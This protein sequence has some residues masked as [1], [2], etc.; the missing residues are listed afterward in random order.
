MLVPLKLR[1]YDAVESRLFI[2]NLLKIIYIIN[3]FR[4][5][6]VTHKKCSHLSVHNNLLLF[7]YIPHLLLEVYIIIIIISGLAPL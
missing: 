7:Y 2:I 1:L 3:K 4:A 5:F 6:A